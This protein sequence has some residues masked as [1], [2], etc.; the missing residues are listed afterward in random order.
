MEKNL[1]HFYI[2]ETNT[3]LQNILLQ[4]NNK[5]KKMPGETV[6]VLHLTE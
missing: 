4:L 3:T 5:N 1:T 2:P 6:F